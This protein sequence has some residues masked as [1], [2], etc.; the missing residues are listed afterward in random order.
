ML[1]LIFLIDQLDIHNARHATRTLYI[2]AW[3]QQY[4]TAAATPKYIVFYNYV[5]ACAYMKYDWKRTLFFK[6]FY[7]RWC[8]CRIYFYCFE[9][10]RWRFRDF[11][12]HVIVV[13]ISTSPIT[14][15]WSVFRKFRDFGIYE[16][17]YSVSRPGTITE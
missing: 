7:I 6:I 4:T 10:F 16:Q 2:H 11:Y 13:I 9:C 17:R 3:Q 14:P 15:V 8:M 5:C 12:C 1:N